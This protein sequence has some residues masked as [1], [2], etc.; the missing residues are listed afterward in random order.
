MGRKRAYPVAGVGKKPS[1]VDHSMGG[2]KSVILS[3]SLTSWG[4]RTRQAC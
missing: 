4:E 2:Q 1:M 3:E